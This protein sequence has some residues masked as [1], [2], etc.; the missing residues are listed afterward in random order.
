MSDEEYTGAKLKPSDF[1]LTD[2]DIYI[3][4]MNT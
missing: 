1:F 3:W 4:D 2:E